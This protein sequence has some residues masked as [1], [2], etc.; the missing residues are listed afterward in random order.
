[1]SQNIEALY[2]FLI[3]IGASIV[4]GLHKRAK[5]KKEQEKSIFRPARPVPIPTPKAKPPAPIGLR[6]VKSVALSDVVKKEV[7]YRKKKP[8]IAKLIGGLKSKKELVL[9]SEILVNKQGIK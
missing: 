2:P 6:A 5:Q 9:L 4:K 8:R 7:F 1:M 3:L